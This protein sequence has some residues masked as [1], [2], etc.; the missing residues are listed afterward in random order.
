MSV[1]RTFEQKAH[2]AHMSRCSPD[3]AYEWLRSQAPSAGGDAQSGMWEDPVYLLSDYVLYRRRDPMI[4]LALARWS[5]VPKVVRRV[6]LRGSPVVRMAAW[7]NLTEKFLTYTGVWADKPELAALVSHGTLSELT[8]FASN[9]SL[10]NQVLGEMFQRGGAFEGISD[11]RWK[12]LLLGVAT[13]PRLSTPWYGA[14]SDIS[15]YHYDKVFEQAW[16]IAGHAPTTGN[17]AY[18]VLKVLELCILPYGL[19]DKAPA[20]ISRWYS[21]PPYKRQVGDYWTGPGFSLRSRLADLLEANEV[22]RGSDDL[23]LRMSYFRRLNP[24]KEPGW[25]QLIRAEF[26]TDAPDA[27][28]EAALENDALWQTDENRLHLLE[29]CRECPDPKSRGNVLDSHRRAV[30]RMRKKSPG[31]IPEYDYEYREPPPPSLDSKMDAIAAQV[32]ALSAI[33]PVKASGLAAVP[34]WAWVMTG[35]VVGLLMPGLHWSDP[36]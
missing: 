29:L 22:L 28:L 2:A 14:S 8:T 25:P 7:S 6:F 36:R 16:S 35:L 12:H 13:N 17:W 27:C 10:N 19:R 24:R 20:M 31:L 21:D 5:R 32:T 4:D 3:T 26:A 9:P 11:T 30:T 18:V 34:W 15:G 33:K 23:P 1:W